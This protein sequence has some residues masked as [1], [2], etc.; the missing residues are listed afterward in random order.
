MSMSM[1]RMVSTL[2]SLNGKHLEA[3]FAYD[4]LKRDREIE[5]GT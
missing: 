2:K 4:Q 1:G 3:N 5:G